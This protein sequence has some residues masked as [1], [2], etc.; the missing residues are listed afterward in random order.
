MFSGIINKNYEAL[1][2]IECSV[3]F[4][5]GVMNPETKQM[6]KKHVFISFR[7][8]DVQKEFVQVYNKLV[9]ELRLK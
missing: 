4:T 1:S 8:A 6:Q 2:P 7:S 3:L 9:N 5:V